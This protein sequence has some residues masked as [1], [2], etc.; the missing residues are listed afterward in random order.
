M[1]DDLAPR[2]L[3]SRYPDA[4]RGMGT[5]IE[6]ALLPYL[7]LMFGS[8]V[9]GAVGA[10][11]AL[12]LKRPGLALRSLA[13][14]AAGWIAF[15]FVLATVR[16]PLGIENVSVG[17]IIGRIVHFALGGALY[18]MHR[19]HFSGH[20]FKHGTTAPLLGSYLTSILVSMVL[21]SRVTLFLLGV[22]IG[23]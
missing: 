18:V 20:T 12:M 16:G 6:P 4:R 8:L 1:T 17:V 2:P 14:G 22:W 19:P 9:A 10:Y 15:L 7:A 5:L 13:V 23:G 3:L 21:P 11:N